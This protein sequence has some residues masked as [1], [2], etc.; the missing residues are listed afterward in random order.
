[1]T[2]PVVEFQ[3]ITKRFGDVTAL[4]GVSFDL[5]PGQI[6]SLLGPSGCGKTTVLRLI[7]GFESPNQG[8]VLL[9]GETV[10][11]GTI[12]VPP[13]RRRVGMLFQEYALFPHL[14]VAQN[15]AFGL[16]RLPSGEKHSKLRRAVELVR[17]EGLEGRYPHE[18][19][20]GQQQRVA[21]ART[22]APQ[23]VVVLLDEPF[24]N[25]D[26]SLRAQMRSE[27]EAILR[28]GQISTVFVTHDSEEAFATA[29]QVAVIHEGR[30]EQIDTPQT[31]YHSPS[32]PHVARIC[33]AANFIDGII[34]N[35]WASTEVGR[36]QWQSSEEGIEEGS[37][38]SI[39]AHPDDFRVQYSAGG[40]ATVESSEFRGD[41]TVLRI[42]MPSGNVIRTRNVSSGGLAPGTPVRL[43]PASRAPFTA[44]LRDS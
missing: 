4:N 25:V 14:T 3:D 29:D 11:S 27:V 2:T 33:G 43:T 18:L 22:L 5:A 41:E 6:L 15:V 28:D 12:H 42:L 44:F 39:I 1:M 13:E 36:L 37:R 26:A 19:S 10:A 40:T 34:E 7:A 38:V 17:L 30:I 35:E 20:G 31:V 9:R 8:A 24:S 23:P 16:H 21:L 32:C